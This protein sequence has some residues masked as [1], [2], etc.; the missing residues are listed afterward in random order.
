MSR[1]G[2]FGTGYR[3]GYRRPASHYDTDSSIPTGSNPGQRDQQDLIDNLQL[4][5]NVANAQIRNRGRP[6]TTVNN[7]ASMMEDLR[8]TTNLP[9]MKTEEKPQPRPLDLMP[10][11]HMKGLAEIEERSLKAMRYQIEEA[12]RRNSPAEADQQ[13]LGELRAIYMKGYTSLLQK[14]ANLKQ[15]ETSPYLALTNG[16]PL[17][18][19]TPAPLDYVRP[20]GCLDH[21]SL[22]KIG[23]NQ[24]FNPKTEESKS[25]FK[26]FWLALKAYG[27]SIYLETEEDYKKMLE[28]A[29]SGDSLELLYEVNHLSLRQIIDKFS[30]RFDARTSIESYRQ[31]VDEFKR[32]KDEDLQKCMMRAKNLLHK[33]Q[34]SWP[35]EDRPT[36]INEKGMAILKQIIT[37]KTDQFLSDQNYKAR[38]IGNFLRLDTLIDLADDY[39][40][41]HNTA[42][43]KEVVTVFQAA[44]MRPTQTASESQSLKDQ[45]S[46]LQ[47]EKVEINQL[48]VDNEIFK[49]KILELEV[50]AAYYRN[51]RPKT[52]DNKSKDPLHAI[53]QWPKGPKSP[54]P[55]DI[56]KIVKTGQLALPAPR[57]VTPIAGTW[58]SL[59]PKVEE[60]PTAT[61]PWRNRSNQQQYG[62][63]AQQAYQKYNNNRYKN[64]GADKFVFKPQIVTLPDGRHGYNCVPCNSI[65]D[66]SI[67][68]VF[69][70]DYE[71]ILVNNPEAE[72]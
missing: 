27:Q 62:S 3:G 20:R 53:K 48:K 17:P 29:L 70:L 40:R 57:P 31:Q 34:E 43:N 15:L 50:N 30:L 36:L 54:L 42:P 56:D 58:D 35:I 23:S 51:N 9:V 68:C 39:E 24:G 26:H 21:K 4:Q 19:Y 59:P 63:A 14:Q 71:D 16:L 45:V 55:M 8:V 64:P 52:P 6:D 66:Q 61:A 11:E 32:L 65:H 38:Q 46:H 49:S 1:R 60:A 33:L 47:K 18:T 5:L 67:V 44:S 37:T 2:G 69:Y 25:P 22:Q 7:L 41:R 10:I 12:E 28:L 13:A 72:N